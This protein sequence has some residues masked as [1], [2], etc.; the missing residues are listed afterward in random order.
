MAITRVLGVAVLAA[1]LSGPMLL[2]AGE[3]RE[4]VRH[5]TPNFRSAEVAVVASV[6]ADTTGRTIVVDPSV[7]NRIDLH[8]STRLTP[9]EF[10]RMFMQVVA[11]EGLYIVEG[12]QLTLISTTGL[13]RQDTAR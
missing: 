9:K 12:R 7:R 13:V 6:V 10:Y 5:I 11:S 8:S 3:P 2:F 4:T 1:A